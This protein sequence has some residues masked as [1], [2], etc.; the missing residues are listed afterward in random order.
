LRNLNIRTSLD[1]LEFG[2]D[3]NGAKILQGVLHPVSSDEGANPL[4][5]RLRTFT[6]K[7]QEKRLKEILEILEHFP[8]RLSRIRNGQDSG[9]TRRRRS[10]PTGG[11]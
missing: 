4:S 6:N 3:P 7:P 11:Q 5:A 2:Q 8:L 9:N 10:H 1:F